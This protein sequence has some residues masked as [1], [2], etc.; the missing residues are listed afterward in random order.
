[1]AAKA[2]VA[3]LKATPLVR[4]DH[5]TWSTFVDGHVKPNGRTARIIRDIM[6]YFPKGTRVISGL[7]DISDGAWV[8]N[9]HWEYL[10]QTIDK[11]VAS[12]LLSQQHMGCLRLI[13]KGLAS[14]P[15]NPSAGYQG[16]M[17]TPLDRSTDEEVRRRFRVLC[18]AKKDV[19][20]VLNA[21]KLIGDKRF[22]QQQRLLYACT[23]LASPDKSLH[24]TGYALDIKGNNAAICRICDVLG[25]SLVFPEPTKAPYHVHVEFARNVTLPKPPPSAPVGAV[26][27]RSAH[28]S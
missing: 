9:Y 13:R 6:P 1:M 15:P 27:R 10:L 17:G 11:V 18:R 21:A 23:K 20:A 25:A 5:L 28:R 4:Y 22:K 24:R 3:P 2:I 16:E 19:A 14:C 12:G 7:R 8:I 26:S